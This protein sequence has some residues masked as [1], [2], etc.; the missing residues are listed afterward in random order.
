MLMADACRLMAM[1]D[2]GWRWANIALRL[3]CD[4]MLMY[5]DG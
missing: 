1:D 4:L 2:Y 3:V 5:D